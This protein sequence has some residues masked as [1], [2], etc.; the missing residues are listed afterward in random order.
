MMDA[1]TTHCWFD[2]HYPQFTSEIR[3][4]LFDNAVR[5]LFT[6]PSTPST[7]TTMDPRSPSTATSTASRALMPIR[8][9][10]SL[11]TSS[12]R[13]SAPSLT[14]SLAWASSPAASSVAA[15]PPVHP[16]PP[17]SSMASSSSARRRATIGGE[18]VGGGTELECC[19]EVQGPPLLSLLL[20][21][22]VSLRR[23]TLWP[24]QPFLPR[25]APAPPDNGQWLAGRRAAQR[26]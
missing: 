1:L 5:P 13:T 3:A 9:S 18:V 11:T 21:Y 25:V 7:A 26:S 19:G 8:A 20:R 16:P 4:S 17:L 15:M 23:P 6:L 24:R 22:H 12:L 2:A 10:Q 14:L